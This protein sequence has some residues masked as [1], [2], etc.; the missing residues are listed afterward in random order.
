VIEDAYGLS[1]DDVAAHTEEYVTVLGALLRGEGVAHDG[2]HYRV[3]IP[4]T[5]TLPQ[6]V[7][8]MISALAPRLLQVAGE[9]TDGTILWMANASA[10]KTHVAPR[11]NAAAT[12]AGRPKP[13]IVALP[14]AVITMRSA[15]ICNYGVPDYRRILIGGRARARR[16]A[17]G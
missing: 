12:A 11:M 14:V 17:I 2:K 8:L 16:R 1:Y 15:G 13:R 9:R 7:S 6:P 5:S 4:V 3:H 10:I